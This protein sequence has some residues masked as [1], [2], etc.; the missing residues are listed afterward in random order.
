[1]LSYIF[2]LYGHGKLDPK[3]YVKLDPEAEILKENNRT[4]SFLEKRLFMP[5]VRLE[6]ATPQL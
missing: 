1:M 3:F 4:T 2:D 6:L 5:I